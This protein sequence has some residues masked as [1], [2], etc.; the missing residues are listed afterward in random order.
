MSS[1]DEEV[2]P[3]PKKISTSAKTA[4]KPRKSGLSKKKDEEYSVASDDDDDDLVPAKSKGKQPA[5]KKKPPGKEKADGEEEP[6]KKFKRVLLLRL[7]TNA[8]LFIVTMH[9][10]L[11]KRLHLPTM[12]QRR[13]QT[14]LQIALQDLLSCSLAS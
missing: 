12:V 5:P 7:T 11:R 6:K 4:A 14:V 13:C 8:N 3:L 2:S 9:I 1:D 10:K